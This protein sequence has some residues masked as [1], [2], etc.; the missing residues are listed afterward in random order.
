MA[1][2]CRSRFLS[3]ADGPYSV[4]VIG[5]VVPDVD[6]RITVLLCVVPMAAK[7]HIN[8]VI[9]SLQSFTDT[10]QTRY[11]YDSMNRLTNVVQLTNGANTAIA[12]SQ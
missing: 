4:G 10:I 6:M 7:A 11:Q 1:R 3:L 12:W 8:Q 9:T 5:G 2:Y